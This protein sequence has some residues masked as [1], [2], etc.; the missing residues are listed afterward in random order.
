M[1]DMPGE[2]DPA[3]EAELVATRLEFRAHRPLAE[4]GPVERWPPARQRGGGIGE[5]VESLL[6]REGRDADD[7]GSVGGLARDG[8]GPGR[9]RI[10]EVEVDARR[11]D[12][13]PVVGHPGRM[14]SVPD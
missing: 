5:D 4:D 10:E 1:F 8:S 14:Q 9:R 7:A 3:T 2:R 6:R 11:D 12:G 13:D